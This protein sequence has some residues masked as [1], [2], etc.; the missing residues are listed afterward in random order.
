MLGLRCYAGFFS[1]CDKRSCLSLVAE[2]FKEGLPSEGVCGEPGTLVVVCSPCLSLHPEN[3]GPPAKVPAK[4]AQ[5][6][7]LLLTALQG[8]LPHAK[9]QFP[10]TR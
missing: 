2:W 3:G 9:E 1:S 10:S 7:A 6:A 4:A 5:E 8:S